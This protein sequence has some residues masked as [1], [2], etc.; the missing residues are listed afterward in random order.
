M[1]P[2]ATE[3]P[4]MA[5]NTSHPIVG[6]MTM[7]PLNSRVGSMALLREFEPSAIDEAMPVMQR[8]LLH[9]E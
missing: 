7:Q 1:L 6:A 3:V 2:R 4:S 8:V 5:G 9:R